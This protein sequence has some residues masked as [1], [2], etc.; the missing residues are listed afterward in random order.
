F[1]YHLVIL[2][3]EPNQHLRAQSADE[4]AT[5]PLREQVGVVE[6]QAGG[7]DDRIPIVDR[8]LHAVLVDDSFADR[9]TGVI[10]AVHHGRPSVILALFDDVQLI[11]AAWTVLVL[12]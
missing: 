10:N 6:R 5:L 4:E 8:V 1:R 2:D 3:G 7:R 9:F 11:A 12:P